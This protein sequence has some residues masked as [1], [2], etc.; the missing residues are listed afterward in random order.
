MT[1]IVSS[2]RGANKPKEQKCKSGGLAIR[3]Q[4]SAQLAVS[5]L[6][7]ITGPL[8]ASEFSREDS[9]GMTLTQSSSHCIP[10]CEEWGTHI[11]QRFPV[12]RRVHS[13]GFHSSG[14]GRARS[15]SSPTVHQ[16]NGGQHDVVPP[17]RGRPLG[18]REGSTDRPHGADKN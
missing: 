3:S 6:T 9:L 16:V 5:Q 15:G 10:I 11:W 13:L 18:S 14:T 12:I 7:E 2:L 1:G 8:S 17:H 4:A